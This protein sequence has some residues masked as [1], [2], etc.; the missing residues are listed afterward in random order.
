MFQANCPTTPRLSGDQRRLD[1]VDAVLEMAAKVSP[2][3]ISTS[4]IARAVGVSQGAVFKHFACKDDIWLAV[5]EAIAERLMAVVERAVA[6]ARTPWQALRDVF[7]AHARFVATHPGVP[8]F[9][10]HELQQAAATP[11]KQRIQGLMSTYRQRLI[12]LLDQLERAGEL[13]D[14]VDKDAAVSLFLGSVQGLVM[15]SMLVCPGAGVW[16]QAEVVTTIFE[17]GIRRKS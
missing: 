3:M 14:E 5:A 13:A 9:I 4:D 11:V 1:I 7:M 10:C 15:Q 6:P 16:A 12:A 2:A 8:P 17:R